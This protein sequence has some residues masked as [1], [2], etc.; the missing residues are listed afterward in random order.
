MVA[1][2]RS[3]GLTGSASYGLSRRTPNLSS[4]HAS[5]LGAH[6]ESSREPVDGFEHWLTHF[7]MAAM[8]CEYW[9][10][11]AMTNHP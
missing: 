9:T 1:P 6:A 2:R 8:L 7:L 10:V 3:Q 11:I 5:L 4:L